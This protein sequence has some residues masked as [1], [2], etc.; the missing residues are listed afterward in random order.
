MVAVYQVPSTLTSTA[1]MPLCWAQATPAIV[2]CPAATLAFVFG[3]S[4]RDSVLIGPC[5]DQP[6]FTQNAS[7]APNVVSSMSTT[8]LVADT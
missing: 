4:M 2:T 1:S 3:T 8:H 7:N 5:W 6:C